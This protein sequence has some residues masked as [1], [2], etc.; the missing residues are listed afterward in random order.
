MTGTFISFEGPD[1]SGKTSTLNGVLAQL[2]G[3]TIT[4]PVVTREPGG[5]QIAEKNS[6]NYIRSK[7]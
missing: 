6:P 4:K 5:S 2:A 7:Q 3:N 1:G